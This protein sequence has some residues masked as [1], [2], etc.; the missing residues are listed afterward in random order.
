MLIMDWSA[1][2]CSSDLVVF[3]VPRNSVFCDGLVTS[4]VS[5]V[6]APNAVSL[7]HSPSSTLPLVFGS[8]SILV[9]VSTM[10]TVAL[11]PAPAACRLS[12]FSKSS[13]AIENNWPTTRHGEA[14]GDTVNCSTLTPKL[15]ETT[16][17]SSSAL[18]G[19]PSHPQTK[20][21]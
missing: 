3:G 14:G 4:T 13:A 21:E 11:M 9:L 16:R 18:P 2:V 20:T 19:L 12:A 5:V 7:A 8:S 1:D 10:R 15:G 6:L 17:P